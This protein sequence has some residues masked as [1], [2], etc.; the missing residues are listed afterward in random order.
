MSLPIKK[1]VERK[2]FFIIIYGKGGIGK[3]TF[4]CSF[5][6]P[7]VLDIEQGAAELGADRIEEVPTFKTAMDYTTKIEESSYKTLV[8]DSLDQLELLIWKEVIEEHNKNPKI[9]VKAV[10]ILDIPYAG[11][12]SQSLSRWTLFRDALRKIRTKM[13]V[14][15]IGHTQIKTV[16]DPS[17]TAAYDKHLI[18]IQQKAA[19][20][21][22]ESCDAVLFANYETLIHVE[23]GKPKGKAVGDVKRMLY[24]IEG[25]GFQAKNRLG[26]PSEIPLDYKAFMASIKNIPNQKPEEIYSRVTKLLSQVK[27]LETKKKATSHIESVK[28]DP[29]QLLAAEQ[30]LQTLVAS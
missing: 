18:K 12:Y 28:S 1:G 9:K 4:A 25:A 22:I 17:A 30:K 24:T 5:E 3:T 14:I 11:G 29:N 10:N 19:D 8:V 6:N 7:I 15:L 20:L 26:L 23:D 16:N 13:N 2:P 21:L 27:D